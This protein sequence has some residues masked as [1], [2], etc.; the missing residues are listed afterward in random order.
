MVAKY[1]G[2]PLAWGAVQQPVVLLYRGVIAKLAA[3]KRVDFSVLYHL[4]HGHV[5]EVGGFN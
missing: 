3:V 2:R 1:R 4:G 5:H